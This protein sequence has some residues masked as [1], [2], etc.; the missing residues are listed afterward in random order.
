MALS[1]ELEE[2]VLSSLTKG[3]NQ[4]KYNDHMK[5]IYTN[6]YIDD[7]YTEAEKR[8]EQ[9]YKDILESSKQ[10]LNDYISDSRGVDTSNTLSILGASIQQNGLID[11]AKNY[12]TAKNKDTQTL[13]NNY[14]QISK[15]MSS[16]DISQSEYQ[17]NKILLQMIDQE[18]ER[19]GNSL[20]G[21]ARNFQNSALRGVQNFVLGG[22][23]AV[24]GKLTNNNAINTAMTIAGLDENQQEQVRKG[25]Y[26]QYRDVFTK[27]GER[28]IQNQQLLNSLSYNGVAKLAMDGG[29]TVGE[30]TIPILLGVVTGNIATSAGT[31]AGMSAK[32]IAD[33]SANAS[34]V[35]SLGSMYGDVFGHSYAEAIDSNANTRDAELYAHAM[36][37]A[38]TLSE[39]IG[40]ETIM[41]A[42][43]GR[44]ASS[45]IG[46]AVSKNILSNVNSKALKGMI[47][48]VT[49]IGSESLEEIMTGL[50]D[51]LIKKVALGEDIKADEILP[52]LYEAAVGSIIPSIIFMGM[53]KP[54]VLA[55][56]NNAESNIK[57]QIR[58]A[59]FLTDEQKADMNKRIT[60]ITADARLGI[61]DNY[62]NVFSAVQDEINQS[63]RQQSNIY[64]SV[65]ELR[66]KYGLSGQ[67]MDMLLQDQGYVYNATNATEQQLVDKSK[68][69]NVTYKNMNTINQ[70]LSQAMKADRAIQSITPVTTIDKIQQN[71]KNLVEKLTG[72][73]V[74]F[75][76]TQANG[77]KVHGFTNP[78]S[79][80][81]NI[82]INVG[83]NA[84]DTLA[85]SYHEI[86]HHYKLQHPELYKAFVSALNTKG[87]SEY[88]IEERFG[89][90]IGQTMTKAENVK[91]VENK[92][93]TIF[94]NLKELGSKISNK[95]FGTD[96]NN[97]RV[98]AYNF[99][100]P[101]YLGQDVLNNQALEQQVLNIFQGS[102]NNVDIT[103]QQE[104]NKADESLEKLYKNLVAD[105]K[106]EGQI[107]RRI[108]LKDDGKITETG[109]KFS[110][111]ASKDSNQG[112]F[113]VT[114][115]SNGRKLS[116]GQQRWHKDNGIIDVVGYLPRLYHGTNTGE[117]Y[118]FDTSKA[119]PEGDWGAG[120][121][122]T[123]N[124][125]D[126][127]QNYYG[128]G[129]DW[130]NKVSRLAE[131]IYNEDLDMPYEE[132]E[133]KAREQ[134]E[135]GEYRIDAYGKMKKPAVV[136]K[137]V[138]FEVYDGDLDVDESDYEN[139]DD[140]Y[141]ALNDARYRAV[142]DMLGEAQAYI[143]AKYGHSTWEETLKA[144]DYVDGEGIEIQQ[145]KDKLN[146][147]FIE[148]PEEGFLIANE[149]ARL[150]IE[151]QGYDGIIDPTV[152]EKF[153]A[154][155]I[156]KGT[157]HYIF[158]NPNQIKDID[159][160]NPTE[161]DYI[162]FSKIKTDSEGNPLTI[163]QMVKHQ[164]NK[165]RDDKG[166]PLVTY[167]TQTALT[168]SQFTS[169]APERFS[170]DGYH[171]RGQTVIFTTPDQAMS[172][173][174]AEED[175][176]IQEVHIEKIGTIQQA[177]KALK[178]KKIFLNFNDIDKETGALNE[179]NPK[180]WKN[181]NGEV[182]VGVPGKVD[183][184]GSDLRYFQEGL[185]NYL[186]KQTK[187]K[188][189]E[190]FRN[191]FLIWF[192]KQG[193]AEDMEWNWQY[194]LY[195]YT[196]HPYMIY[197][198]GDAW[199][200][201]SLPENEIKEDENEKVYEAFLTFMPSDYHYKNYHGEAWQNNDTMSVDYY[202]SG[203][204]DAFSTVAETNDLS[205][206]IDVSDTLYYNDVKDVAKQYYEDVINHLET[207]D[208]Y[209]DNKD[210]DTVLEYLKKERK[211]VIDELERAL[212]NRNWCYRN[213][214][215]E[216]DYDIG[217]YIYASLFDN[218]AEDIFRNLKKNR[219][220]ETNDIA[221]HVLKLNYEKNVANIKNTVESL[222]KLGPK[223][224]SEVGGTLRNSFSKH[225]FD[226]VI[227]GEETWE[228]MEPY[229]QAFTKEVISRLEDIKFMGHDLATKAV[230]DF[231]DN[232]KKNPDILNQFFRYDDGVEISSDIIQDNENL[233]F[234]FE[235]HSGEYSMDK[236]D[237]FEEFET[238]VN[239]K[240][241]E[242]LQEF[243]TGW[244]YNTN[245]RQIL[246]V[247]GYDSV[248]VKDTRDY[249]GN[250][251]SEAYDDPEYARDV[252][253]VFSPEQVDLVENKYPT[254]S[255]NMR[256]S[257][258]KG[259]Y[260]NLNKNSKKQIIANQLNE[261]KRLKAQRQA[262]EMWAKRTG[263]APLVKRAENQ[264]AKIKGYQIERQDNKKSIRKLSSDVK[265]KGKTIGTLSK[266]YQ[267]ERYGRQFAEKAK[268]SGLNFGKEYKQL[269]IE[270]RRAGDSIEQAYELTKA[271]K[272]QSM[273]TGNAIKTSMNILNELRSNKIYNKLPNELKT[274]IDAYDKFWSKSGE[275]TNLTLA[276]RILNDATIRE[277][278][279]N[280]AISN[281]VRKQ[282][283][284][285]DKGTINLKQALGGSVEVASQFAKGLEDL[286]QEVKAFQERDMDIER[287]KELQEE[288]DGI[289]KQVSDELKI[290]S[291]Q[292]T[293]EFK[294][295][296]FGSNDTALRSQMTFKTETQAVMGGNINTKLMK[297][298]DN[299]QKGEIR[300]KR[301]IVGM[302]D[303]LENF[304]SNSKGANKILGVKNWS[305]GLKESLS[306]KSD[307][308]DTG[309]EALP[310][311]PKSFIMS[312]A[313]H[314]KNDQNMTH[315]S[316]GVI[317]VATDDNGKTSITFKNGEGV[318]I[319]DE[320]LYKRG[321]IDAAYDAG[322][323]VKL[324]YD[325]VKKLISMLN[326][327]ELAFVDAVKN[328]Y[329]YTTKLTNE[330]SN[331]IY[332]YDL[333]TVENYFPIH[334]W[335]TGASIDPSKNVRLGK[336]QNLD[337]L[338]Y[339]TNA[340]WLQ[341]RAT[342]FAPI[343][344]ENI[345]QVLD[346]SMNNVATFY[347]YAEALRDNEILLNS[348][349]DEPVRF[350]KGKQTSTL[351]EALGYLSSSYLKDYNNMTRYIVGL[352]RNPDS[353]FRSL[354][355]MNTLSFNIGTWLTQ[356]MSFFNTIKYYNT[357]DF[358]KGINP[359]NNNL[360]LNKMIR[361]YYEDL[362][363]D[364]SNVNNYQLARS[365]IS[366]ATPNLDYRAL[367]YKIPMLKGLYDPKLVEKLGVHGIEAFDNIAVT[368][369]ARMQAWVL[370]QD[371]NI[372]FG[373]E[374]YFEKLG[375]N[376]T[377]MLVETQPEFSQI[378]R[379]NMFRTK[380]GLLR[381]LNLF[382]TPANQMFNN[383]AQS[384]LELRYEQRQGDKQGIKEATRT[385][386]KS[387]SG[388][389]ISSALVGLVR[390][391]RDTIRSD[392]DDDDFKDKWLAQSIIS[393]L[394]PT[395]ILDDVA[396]F[397][398]SHM[399][400][401]KGF[402]GIS[403]YD[404]NSPETT[405]LNGI[406]NLAEK[407]MQLSSDKYGP[408][409]KIVDV[410]KALGVITPIDTK[411]VVRFV[412]AL[413]KY[414]SPDIYRS[415]QLQGNKT[416]YN[417][418]QNSGS[419][420]ATFYKAYEATRDDS[421]IKDY[422]YIK[423]S[424]SG[425]ESAKKQAFERALR[426]NLPESDVDK[427]M[428]I[429]GGYKK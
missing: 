22:E 292:K 295:N 27:G 245:W 176:Y 147:G 90:Y 421:L 250:A 94:E 290:Q 210:F 158:F 369:A 18:L 112:S 399:N 274:K 228:D 273:V 120:I 393:L 258:T 63:Y 93:R 201:L 236:F 395:L 48:L 353:R 70:E 359:I 35:A 186:V 278:I 89:N 231:T 420:M 254:M 1:K 266:A 88:E 43:V 171:F 276:K 425:T 256:F 408:A 299:L 17:K 402:G 136:G 417:K 21:M 409:K 230:Q 341:E 283:M 372:E 325:E 318:R 306:N 214:P 293:K 304:L 9:E 397:I 229:A 75:V 400:D 405:F 261:I 213:L 315:I 207:Y 221:K 251:P 119:S 126:V 384:A 160:L 134:L 71:I 144:L 314:L 286:R 168:N 329:E 135:K 427:Y 174:Y 81:Q 195:T 308:I 200:E 11:F 52:S 31:K 284:D 345:A 387:I 84:N 352:D 103:K 219:T 309:I 381:T 115:D 279:G 328:I 164:G 104:H 72:K 272:E 32:A 300:K 394:S 150:I 59:T 370:S 199:N 49:D 285:N 98:S 107:R 173:S 4:D 166:R 249:G 157:R 125:Q 298:D 101:S 216:A 117:F 56:V 206:V 282:L 45:L 50:T 334:V 280:V 20:Q 347:G 277:L 41:S 234:Y 65:N 377:K 392:D 375:A 124:E 68:I 322:N 161:S 327:E 140:Y 175:D 367:G 305:K 146:F 184:D 116:K 303:K 151:S 302:Y 19:K 407:M 106:T 178:G 311:A 294:K 382:G 131:N 349:Y 398:M 390:A 373:S 153:K 189:M 46:K 211:L 287:A 335:R 51:P 281:S 319:P 209:V 321:K 165:A 202:S 149:V 240:C 10:T 61:N 15:R 172:N 262:D 260:K 366:M 205:E 193:L 323:T 291:T 8:A 362:G 121:Y 263:R 29:F 239:N 378:N 419:D 179:Y 192:K 55:Q 259:E 198:G 403:S 64:N 317:R 167:N 324:S 204:K 39:I 111:E 133:E 102:K 78:N 7:Q 423:G 6:K 232:L 142:D 340:G 288:A 83:Q 34:K 271:I 363:F 264:R 252:F 183:D 343:Y 187:F 47:A 412:T 74:V 313:M 235:K 348:V 85:A 76:N 212:T 365:F 241:F 177:N 145:M 414:T 350:G 388:V 26:N 42:M 391:L 342:S 253:M 296:V 368:A 222:D 196:K 113:L 226:A 356:P 237:T 246:D 426:A 14:T 376:L 357:A 162:R 128:G 139:E 79:N 332:G 307:W 310:R 418:W 143:E 159:N 97:T 406:T 57:S 33:M 80:S 257:K 331:R 270:L 127:N 413:L 129:Q 344:L 25:L 2:A 401:G 424:K 301:A 37:S 358:L 386:A 220:Y 40:G 99:N 137:T 267:V 217:T 185:Q 374:E 379:A 333:A 289:K 190:D 354:M 218:L 91:S 96:V 180:V 169:F 66:E 105:N 16:P 233:K 110:K 297:L 364:T 422:G 170:S 69:G 268:N 77:E 337:A 223:E 108:D 23:Q 411:G 62:D 118:T 194:K 316:G 138:L 385:L 248:W 58:T 163:Q 60:E 415:Y 38:E 215:R 154:M 92:T 132:A 247:H 182:I 244:H 355:A 383:L 156:P 227:A 114:E 130:E 269:F 238:S 360:K 3:E 224:M 148:D 86:G 429:L 181:K 30:M 320:N 100:D 396:Q 191:N 67:V 242:R 188:N 28:D 326:E 416:A 371:P 380:N 336:S 123:D 410:I 255:R 197:G 428:E 225:Y 389:I 203:I 152:S 109:T 82:Y 339:L 141:D 361:Q 5:K 54:M 208:V 122:L 338:S 155:G 13:L 53:S 351:R 265:A 73:Q 24:I 275:Q 330:V 404:F 12:S 243:L 44:P 87:L 95:A 346:R 36:A 312:L